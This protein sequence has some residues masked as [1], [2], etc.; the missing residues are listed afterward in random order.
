MNFTNLFTFLTTL[1]ENNH[2]PWF[3]ENRK[4]YEEVKADWHKTVGELIKAIAEFDPEI[5]TLEPKNCVFRINRDVRF[6]KD[7]SPYKTNMGAYFSKGGKKSK[8]GGYY[9]HL[10]PEECFLAGGMWMPEPAEL[11]A[12]RQEIDYHFDEFKT[13]VD[14]KTFIQQWG[15]L[16]G[17]KLSSIPKGFEKENPAADYLK[18]K[19]FVVTRK[20]TQSEIEK[21]DFVKLV[22]QSFREVKPLNDFFNKAVDM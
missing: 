16:E 11:Q 15:K 8:Y 19:S 1:K 14:S 5:G 6:A 20:L 13:I 9:V 21:S 2:K 4:W 10:D 12:L 17:E 7:K 18:H 3:D 22:V